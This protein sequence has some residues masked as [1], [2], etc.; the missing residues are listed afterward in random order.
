MPLGW[1]VGKMDNVRDRVL[2]QPVIVHVP[3]IHVDKP[4]DAQVD[5]LLKSPRV[6]MPA[7][8]RGSAPAGVG[9]SP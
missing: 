9:V 8:Q 2:A 3:K 6:V 4:S 1:M 7:M 5:K